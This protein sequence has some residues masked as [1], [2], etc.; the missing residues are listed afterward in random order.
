[1]A[2]QEIVRERFYTGTPADGTPEQKGN[3][4][5]QQFFRSL[6]RAEDR[7]LIGIHEIAGAIYLRLTQPNPEP[8]EEPEA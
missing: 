7:R 8:G 3:T 6:G 5:R 4:R 2:D 1:M